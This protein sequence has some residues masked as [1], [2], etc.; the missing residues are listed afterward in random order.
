MPQVIVL[1]PDAEFID[2]GELPDQVDALLQ[3]GVSAYRHDKTEADSLFHQALA[4]APGELPTYYCLYKIHTYQGNLDRALAIA[5]AGL[6]EAAR[7]AGWS[8]DHRT[9]EPVPAA[10]TGP[11]RFALYTLKALAFIRLR[12]L[13]REQADV[14]LQELSRLDPAGCVGWSVIAD[15][16]RGLD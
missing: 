6:Q 11:G 15:L 7:Q 12:R 3:Q 4:L 1:P 5:E 2:F 8:A 9:W 14:L 10:L 13:E 16:A